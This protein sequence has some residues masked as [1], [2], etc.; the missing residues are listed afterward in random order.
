MA[1][2]AVGQYPKSFSHINAARAYVQKICQ[3]QGLKFKSV[4]RVAPDQ[5]AIYVYYNTAR[6]AYEVGKFSLD[7]KPDTPFKGEWKAPCPASKARV[8]KARPSP[9]KAYTGY[10]RPSPAVT[11]TSRIDSGATKHSNV[12]KSPKN[13]QVAPRMSSTSHNRLVE[14]TSNR[15]T[16]IFSKDSAGTSSNSSTKASSNDQSDIMLVDLGTPSTSTL[17]TTANLGDFPLIDLST[18]TVGTNTLIDLGQPELTVTEDFAAL[19][20]IFSAD[21]TM[22]KD[23][24]LN[25]S[26]IFHFDTGN[27]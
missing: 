21:A 24:G 4:N 12:K 6:R 7:K 23:E 22:F 10:V 18:A 20:G 16:D 3:E 11:T 13:A 27:R 9:P 14:T 2:G 1:Q 8:S 17:D 15:S 19:I 25:V 5:L 26:Q